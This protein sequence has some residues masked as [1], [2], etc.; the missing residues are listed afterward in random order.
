M[1]ANILLHALGQFADMPFEFTMLK[2]ME[3]PV[4]IFGRSAPLETVRNIIMSLAME[5]NARRE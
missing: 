4:S 5:V 2:G 3:K 1:A